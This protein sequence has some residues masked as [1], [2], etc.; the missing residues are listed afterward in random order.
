MAIEQLNYAQFLY[1]DAN[2]DTYNKRGEKEGVRQAVD[3]SAAPTAVRAWGKESKRHSVRKIVYQDSTTFRTKSVI[4]YTAAAW[5]AITINSSTLTFVIPGSATGV[6]YTAV[7]KIPENLGGG[8]F[9]PHLG[10]HA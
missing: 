6:V 4:F 7:K 2:A 3:G 9:S 5:E 1:V 8:L 10:E